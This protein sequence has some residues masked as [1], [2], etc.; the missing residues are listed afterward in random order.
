MVDLYK[1]VDKGVCRETG[2]GSDVG[3]SGD[4]SE[5]GC[6]INSPFFEIK[7]RVGLKE[8]KTCAAGA[9]EILSGALKK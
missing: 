9:A 5:C 8:I 6:G 1:V 3:L 2:H 7:G 4:A